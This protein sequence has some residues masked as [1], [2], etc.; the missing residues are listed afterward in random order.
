MPCACAVAI[1]SSTSRI[2]VAASRSG[3]L[4][5]FL[6][7]SMSVGPV[8]YSNTMNETAPSW[9]ASNTGTMLGWA[10]RLTARASP[11]HCATEAA[12]AS[13]LMILTAT[14]RCR[15]GS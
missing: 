13:G 5:R 12:S 3:S 8:T 7:R 9:S 15:R 6:S 2:S 10:R 4:P 14:S 1:A 11:S